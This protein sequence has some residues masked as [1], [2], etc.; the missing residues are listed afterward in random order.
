MICGR[1]HTFSAKQFAQL[2]DH[3]KTPDCQEGNIWTQI[4]IAKRTGQD[5]EADRLTRKALGIHRPMSEEAKEKLRQHNEEHKDDIKL[6]RKF[7]RQTEKR[8]QEKLDEQNNPNRSN[9][10]MD[11]E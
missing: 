5:Y 8:I 4:I 7:N 6:R 3:W 10:S 11:S 2:K 9:K 1:C